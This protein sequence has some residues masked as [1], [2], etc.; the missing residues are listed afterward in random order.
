[1]TF[2]LISAPWLPCRRASGARDWIAPHDI[3]SDF[4]ADPILALDFPRPDWNAAVSELLIGVVSATIPPQ[5]QDEWADLWL[6]PPSSETLGA[7][8]APLAFAFDFDGDGPRCFQDFDALANAETRPIGS[9]LIDAPGDNTI[10]QNKD[11][12]V[13][14]GGIAALSLPF[15]AAAVITLQT[16]APSGGSGHRTSMRGGGPLSLLIAPRRKHPKFGLI[17]ALWESVWSNVG[18]RDPHQPPLSSQLKP[19]DTRWPRVFPWLAATRISS[20]DTPTL[21]NQHADLL[22][23]FFGM[24]RRIRVDLTTKTAEDC[25]LGGPTDWGAVTNYRTQNYGVMY[26]GWQHPLSPYYIDKKN[27]LLPF[28]PQPGLVTYEDWYAWWGLKDQTVEAANIKAWPARLSALSD[29]E[30]IDV[31]QLRQQSLRAVGFDMDNMKARSWVDEL[32]PY[33]EPKLNAPNWAKEFRDAVSFLVGGAKAAADALKYE[34]RRNSWA[35][36]DGKQFKLPD[37]APKDA[38]DDVAAQL[39]AETQ[40]RFVACL[41]ALH[42]GDPS[43][44]ERNVRT[45]FLNELRKTGLHLFDDAAGTDTLAEQNARRLIEARKGLVVALSRQGKVATALGI[46]A[47]KPKKPRGAGKGSKP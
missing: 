19:T 24:P 29:N 30:D 1:M 20:N 8:L 27:G 14:R 31:T 43:D 26:S 15:A 38:F 22:Q 21:P 47:A 37:N 4:E 36:W 42:E 9:L 10:K 35:K 33:F 28:H 3:T 5:D 13:K 25:S 6:A 46:V 45:D 16:Y 23:A 44:S 34:L 41:A 2:N 7:A 39:W 17:S 32:I 11:L 40:E 12:F 18:A